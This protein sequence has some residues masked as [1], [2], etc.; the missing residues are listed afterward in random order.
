MP[1]NLDKPIVVFGAG[2]K[3]GKLIVQLLAE[4]G[5]YVRAIG[6]KSAFAPEDHARIR[7]NEKYVSYVEGVDVTN[8]D[9]VLKALHEGSPAGAV[10]AV[11]AKPGSSAL[12]VDCKGAYHT[13]K[14]CLACNVPKLA[15]LSAGAVTRP[16]SLGSKAVNFLTQWSYGDCPYMDAKMAGEEAVRDLYRS[17]LNNNDLSYVIIRGAAALVDKSPIPVDNLLV[18]QG[19]VY[20]SAE[21][22]SR[23]NIAEMVVSALSKGKATDCVTFEVAPNVKLYKNDQGNVLDLLGLPSM[24]QTTEPDLPKELAHKAMTYSDLLDGLVNDED[25]EQKYRSIIS[26]YRGQG[27]PL[28]YAH[29]Y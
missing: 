26:D 25:L 17:P 15:F 27:F 16:N 14:A 1:T 18:M 11:T 21:S 22:I 6:H 19:D 12:D 29:T 13:A 8:Y 7:G 2:G 24:E 5:Q 9:Q 4:Q 3:T 10:W 20:S 28:A 23:A